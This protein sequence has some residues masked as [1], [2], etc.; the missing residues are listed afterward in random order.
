MPISVIQRT[1][2]IGFLSFVKGCEGFQS[3]TICVMP[4]N[5]RALRVGTQSISTILFSKSAP[6]TAVMPRRMEYDGRGIVRRHDFSI[7]RRE[8]P[9]LCITLSLLSERGRRDLRADAVASTA[10]RP[11][12]VTIASRPSCERDGRIYRGDLPDGLSGI[13]FESG[14]DTD[15]LICPAGCLQVKA[16]PCPLFTPGGVGPV[17]LYFRVKISRDGAAPRNT[18]TTFDSPLA[19][20][21]KVPDSDIVT[22][23]RLRRSRGRRAAK[24][25]AAR[26]SFS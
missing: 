4:P 11:T 2:A 5:M 22:S 8:T 18:R 15:L 1:R 7:P 13:F 14:L 25:K 20:A 23:G 17:L 26:P 19:C 3:L 10:S 12:S 21:E 16:L 6:P 9:G 24:P